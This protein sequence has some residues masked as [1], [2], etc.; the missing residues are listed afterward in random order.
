[1]V[2]KGVAEIDVVGLLVL[3][4]TFVCV[5]VKADVV[6]EIVP[7]IVPDV[8]I[9]FGGIIELTLTMILADLFKNNTD[10]YALIFISID[11]SNAKFFNY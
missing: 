11:Y 7:E 10:K 9:G 1:M 8:D 3:F 2:F 6:P 5:N 4:R